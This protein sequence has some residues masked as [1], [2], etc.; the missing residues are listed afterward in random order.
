MD[1]TEIAMHVTYET[2]WNFHLQLKRK[3]V[4]LK[5]VTE[6]T[7]D[8][9][10]YAKK[11]TELFE[12][13]HLTGVRRNFAVVDRRE[14]LLHSISHEDQPLSHAIIS[15]AKPLV[16]A[17]YFLFRTLWN[18]SI[19]AEEKIL[20]IEQG[21]KPLVTKTLRDPHE[22]Q[23]L[24]FDLLDSAKQEVLMLLFHNALGKSFLN[25]EHAQKTIQ[26]I[27]EVVRR[28]GIRI[29]ILTSKDMQEHIEKT[30]T[31]QKIITTKSGEGQEDGRG[32]VVTGN[33]G[34]LEIHLI[35]S[36]QQQERLLTKVSFLIVDSKISLIEELKPS[37]KNNK[38]SNEELSL[39]TY[40]NNESMILTYISIFEKLWAQTELKIKIRDKS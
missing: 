28:N 11:L 37:I 6:I 30:I 33:K 19:P 12:I 32:V 15:N 20:E 27:N 35:D 14:C 9:I 24:V 26:L 36:S 40:S 8:N 18:Q 34:K 7:R 38:N 29:R 1:H 13:R 31:R 10:S 2:I 23:R 39:A 3:G 17:Q 4:K 22:I 5:A 25:V 16:E 21:M